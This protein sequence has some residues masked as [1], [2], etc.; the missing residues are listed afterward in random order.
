[1]FSGTFYEDTSVSR[2]LKKF[3]ISLL[4]Q[5]FIFIFYNGEYKAGKIEKNISKRQK[6]DSRYFGI[7]EIKLKKK[8]EIVFKLVSKLT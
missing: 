3:T 7:L 6:C 5:H 4:S 8:H 1:M 2:L